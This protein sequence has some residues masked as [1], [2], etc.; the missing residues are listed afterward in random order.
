MEFGGVGS[1]AGCL[2]DGRDLAATA[3][4]V[5]RPDQ[6]VVSY[7]LGMST[8]A[9]MPAKAMAMLEVFLLFMGAI[10]NLVGCFGARSHVLVVFVADRNGCE[11][12]GRCCALLC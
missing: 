8:E 3:A 7:G 1:P 11:R 12:K 5:S 2:L 4:K 6:K 10:V 9:V